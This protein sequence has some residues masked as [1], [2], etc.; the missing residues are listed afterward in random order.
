MKISSY[1]LIRILPM[2]IILNVCFTNSY[3][4]RLPDPKKGDEKFTQWGI[5]DGNRVRTLYSNH[6][7]I[8]RWPDQPSGEWPKGTGHSY[9]D[10][11]AIIVSAETQNK[12][13]ETIHPM[14]TNYREFIDTDPITGIAWGWA[15]VPGY[16]NPRQ[17][18]PARSDDPV[19]WP[20]FWPGKMSD[21]S[22]PGWPGAWNGFFGKG[23]TNA[24][25]ETYFISDDSPDK[26]WS[27]D[28]AHL[29]HPDPDDTTRGGLG[30]DI[31][32]RGFQWSHVLAQDVIFWL[33]EITNEGKV[34]YEHV[35]FSQYIDWGVGGTT[36]SGDD[37]GAYNVLLDMAFAWDFDG[38]GQPGKWG[39][40]GVV[41]Y[42]FLESPGKSQDL[43]DNDDDGLVDE[44]RTNPA[45]EWLD[46]PPYGVDD[47]IAFETFYKR[48]P[49]P[50]FSGDEDADWV[51]FTDI[52]K[53]G[54]WD[55]GEPLNDDVGTDGIGPFSP[56]YTGPDADGS[57]RNGM[58]DQGEPNFGITDKDESDQIG[59][60][61]FS[62][63]AVHDYELQNDE[64]NWKLFSRTLL[65][66]ADL[67]LEG[68]RNLGMFF[69]SGK[70]PLKA[71]QTERFSMA[72]L[73]SVKDFIDVL[74]QNQILNSSMARKK[75]TVQQIYN[76]DYQFAKPPDKPVLRAVPGDGR[77]V[78]Q[79][80]AL[81]EESFDPFLREKDFEG[82]LI[83]KSTEPTFL[84]NLIITNTYG[85]LTFQKPIAQFDLD[86]GIKGLHPVDIEGVK[87]NIGRD[88]GLKHFF[89]DSDVMNGRT[90]YY[91]VVSYDRG[92]V[93]KDTSGVILTDSRGN[94]KGLAPSFSTSIIQ[95]DISGNIT[96]DVNTAVATPRSP[97]AGFILPEIS[98]DINY[99][100]P[101]TGVIS[102]DILFNELVKDN[103]T[104]ELKFTNESAHFNG[105]RPS[106]TLTD[107][108]SNSIIQSEIGINVDGQEVDLFDGL[109]V[110]IFNDSSITLVDSATKW[111]G[112][113]NTNFLV[114]VKKPHNEEFVSKLFNE[115]NGKS[116]PYPADYEILFDDVDIDTS[117][118]WGIGRL[119]MPLPF[120]IWNATEEKWEKIGIVETVK[121]GKINRKW[122]W[123]ETVVIMG[124][125][126]A[127][128]GPRSQ[129]GNAHWVIRFF[130]PEDTSIAP[131][132]PGAGD[133]YQIKTK[134]PFRTGE[135]VEFTVNAGKFSS[136]QTKFDMN[137]IAVV[138]NPYV[139]T[140][141][142]EPPNI[143][144]SGRGERRVWFIHLPAECTI[145]IYSV[146]GFLIETLYHNGTSDD[147][148]E[149]WDLTSKDGMN[150]AYG[151]YI[152]HI[153]SSLGEKIGKFALIK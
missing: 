7:E 124:G 61:G 5:M 147:G 28:P 48:P 129:Q 78:L 92:L 107:K 127:H 6:G 17:D 112:N 96:T 81:A 90:Y 30:L 15:P 145:R 4:Q 120:K 9:V 153:E 98:G 97:S 140:S 130:E 116:I 56:I 22:D 141:I 66:I 47:P 137:R 68:G 40:V 29:F 88:S 2:L 21:I 79:W 65:P 52:N 111:L 132:L 13:G 117:H 10:G 54:T 101:G 44:S 146:R 128:L 149:N 93:A 46:T 38:I 135:T 125:D 25:L 23:I 99:S 41:G 72:L 3:A 104:Y 71:G 50:H 113:P 95:S 31:S 49:T 151:I 115:T 14:S 103:N 118:E 20:S 34:D 45:G 83:Y 12:F 94:V 148:E 19:T 108:T 86:N 64:E 8:S 39:P 59:L 144:K 51:N 77:V 69:S 85:E 133:V 35:Y 27:T 74:D 106:F 150:V 42:A 11:V 37:E 80:D 75:E 87:F 60:T 58:P 152:Y 36:D 110:Q 143:Y 26:E 62:V 70:F 102:V 73:F 121:K 139:G 76:A 131:I 123:D 24:D 32:T 55:N 82:Y 100:G 1:F 53:S 57:E 114:T 89:V 67:V 63:F 119:P 18:S 84:E 109:A 33:Y 136:D 122:D 142:F 43:I 16:S 126:S 105:T 134:K 138:P 91:A